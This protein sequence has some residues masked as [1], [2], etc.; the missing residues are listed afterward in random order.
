M[1]NGYLSP[2]A[3]MTPDFMASG[4]LSI[5]RKT[6]QPQSAHDFVIFET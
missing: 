2:S 1:W 5:K 3:R 4:S 6:E